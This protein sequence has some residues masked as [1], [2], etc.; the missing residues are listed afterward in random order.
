MRPFQLHREVLENQ[1]SR[2]WGNF[3]SVWVLLEVGKV[4]I[5]G[6]IG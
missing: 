1:G 5:V 2:Q 6:G 3:A 4:E